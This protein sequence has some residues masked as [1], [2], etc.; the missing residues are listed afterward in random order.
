M[1]ADPDTVKG[2]VSWGDGPVAHRLFAV[3]LLAFAV[4][5]ARDT[6]RSTAS[7]ASLTGVIIAIALGLGWGSAMWLFDLWWGRRP[8]VRLVDSEPFTEWR[9]YAP[10]LAFMFASVV[11]AL[12]LWG[13]G[14]RFAF[15]LSLLA[16]V[17]ALVSPGWATRHAARGAV[18]LD[19]IAA[20]RR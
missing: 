6:F 12:A 17:Q 4:A 11:G 9:R 18:K 5:A 10:P 2:R 1:K 20:S 15:E 16:A 3:V 13:D 8:S 7:P 19:A 14:R